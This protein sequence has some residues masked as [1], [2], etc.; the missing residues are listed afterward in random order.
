M[1]FGDGGVGVPGIKVVMFE[2]KTVAGCECPEDVE[3]DEKYPERVIGHM[4][5]QGSAKEHAFV[6][7]FRKADAAPQGTVA[8]ASPDGS[9]NCGGPWIIESVSGCSGL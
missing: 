4:Q 3:V 1:P 8:W 5:A 6:V 7:Y 2:A 9:G